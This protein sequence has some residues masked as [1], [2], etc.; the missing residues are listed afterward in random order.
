MYV[1]S[2]NTHHEETILWIR[3]DSKP[4]V[5]K[6]YKTRCIEILTEK[7][8]CLYPKNWD[9]I[10]RFWM[11]HGIEGSKVIKLV[12]V[13][14]LSIEV[15]YKHKL[16]P[17]KCITKIKMSKISLLVLTLTLLVFIDQ[18]NACAFWC[19][20]QCSVP[21]VTTFYCCSYDPLGRPE[22]F[23]EEVCGKYFHKWI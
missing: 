22:S 4:L 1:K 13:Q 15:Q 7:L 3:Y 18:S 2:R 10:N 16:I 17:P 20:S 21:G 12:E 5:I 11:R 19:K 14:F 23:V 8:N 9:P 6:F